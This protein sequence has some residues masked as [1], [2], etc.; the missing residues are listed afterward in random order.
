[1]YTNYGS[2][3][4]KTPLPDVTYTTYSQL[5]VPSSLLHSPSDQHRYFFADFVWV[6]VVWTITYTKWA[7]T[8][9]VTATFVAFQKLWN[10]ISSSVQETTYHKQSKSL[11]WTQTPVW[12][13]NNTMLSNCYRSHLPEYPATT[14]EFEDIVYSWGINSTHYNP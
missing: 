13:A 14:L 2:S 8:K 3:T 10:T 1:M 4:G 5:F 9:L 6:N 11:C 12:S 7:F